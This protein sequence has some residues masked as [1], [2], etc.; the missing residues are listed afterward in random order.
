[1]SVYKLDIQKIQ[2]AFSPAQEI[3]TPDLF[4]GRREEIVKGTLALSNQGG[5]LCIFG[6]RGVGKSSLASQLKLIAEGNKELPNMLSLQRFLPA[7]GLNYLV[8]YVRCDDYVRDIVDLVKRIS[9]GDERNPS[10]FSYTKA[11][12]HYLDSYKQVFSTEAEA[13]ASMIF[14]AKLGG[15]KVKESSYTR[16]ISNDQV[17]E[18]RKLLGTIEKDNLKKTGL[19]ILIDEFDRIPDKSGFSSLVKAC[20]TRYIKFGVVGIANNITELIQDHESIGRQIDM[21][22]VPRMPTDD[23]ERIIK[24]AEYKVE[25]EITF[26]H[27]VRI[28]IAE[29]AEGFPYFVHLLGRE[30]MLLAFQT[31]STTINRDFLEILVKRITEGHLVTIYEDTYQRIVQN[32]WQREIALRVYSEEDGDEISARDVHKILREMDIN[33]PNRLTKELASDVD[34][35]PVLVKVRSGYYRFSDPVFKVYARIRDWKF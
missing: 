26:T 1:M 30:A 35:T 18:F 5:F 12:D 17:Q 34:K 32:S 10:L 13:N 11:G 31:E 19:L 20:S 28:S 3:E 21:I 9:F 29:R 15:T 6:L 2:T 4:V 14:G 7:G 16:H 27:N 33:N 25:K 24:R 22:S 23:L 8:Q